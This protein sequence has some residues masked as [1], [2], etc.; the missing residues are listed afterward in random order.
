[1]LLLLGSD[2]LRFS[3]QFQSDLQEWSVSELKALRF[4]QHMRCSR[5]VGSRVSLHVDLMRV[6]SE[7]YIEFMR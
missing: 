6:L 7:G 1:M 3:V 4:P 2:Q 5:H